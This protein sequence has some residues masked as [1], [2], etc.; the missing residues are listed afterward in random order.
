MQ[1]KNR[2]IY[3][4]PVFILCGFLQVVHAQSQ[5][6][7]PP[8][9]DSTQ[10]I[11]VRVEDLLGKMTIEEKIGQINM[12]CVYEHGLGESEEAFKAVMESDGGLSSPPETIR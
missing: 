5:N 7:K 9:L 2:I 10:P 8:Y 3:L 6:E 12:P 1:I 4:I 11:N